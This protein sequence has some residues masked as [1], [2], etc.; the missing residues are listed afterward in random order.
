MSVMSNIVPGKIATTDIDGLIVRRYSYLN[1]D[2]DKG[3]DVF[4][5]TRISGSVLAIKKSVP[6]LSYPSGER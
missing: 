6:H 4:L 2:N 1:T 3:G 5:I